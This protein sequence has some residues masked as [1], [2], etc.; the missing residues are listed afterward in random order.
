MKHIQI[1]YLLE[2]TINTNILDKIII[3]QGDVTNTSR[4]NNLQ[5][6]KAR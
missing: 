3:E 5:G 4:V 2:F 1:K 6:Y